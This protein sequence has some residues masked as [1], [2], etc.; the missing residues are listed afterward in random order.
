MR[1]VELSVVIPAYNAETTIVSQLEALAAQEFDG[2]WEAIIAD[3]GSVDGTTC[4]VRMFIDQA[5]E[6]FRLVDASGRRG[7][8]H[9]RNVGVSA[10]RGAGIAF[11]DADDVV[12]EHWLASMGGAL[13]K[14]VFAT[15][16]QELELLNP[17]WLRGVYG[18][19][20]SRS[21][22]MWNDVF[23]FGP[24]ANLGIRRECFER[25]GGFDESIMVFE[26]LDF[27]LRAWLV[28]T[29]LEYIPE[30]LVHYRLRDSLGSLWRQSLTYGEAA[31]AIARTLSQ[32]GR[33]A[34]RRWRGAKNWLWLL[35][36]FP[37]LRSR[38]GRARWVV[39][40]GGVVGRLKGSFRFRH[41]LL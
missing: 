11:C 17:S 20:M 31:P 10:A 18:T 5:G 40:A 30:A 2:E 32:H 9:A 26:D 7:A 34:P 28:G 25:L 39:V 3:N 19:S 13:R 35:R 29:K 38:P 1:A 21:L 4:V 23:P 6:R 36:K 37:T 14:G 22:Q 16:P 12:G 24:T 15:G 41:L 27:C 8:A 33:P